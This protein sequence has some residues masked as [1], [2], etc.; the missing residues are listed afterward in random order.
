[1]NNVDETASETLNVQEKFEEESEFSEIY[2]N[3]C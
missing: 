1:M 3:K 2:I